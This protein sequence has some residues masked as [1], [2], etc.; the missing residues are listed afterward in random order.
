MDGGTEIRCWDDLLPDA[1]ELIF[2]KLSLQELLTVAPAVCKSWLRLVSGPHFWQEIDIEE[3]SRDN[4]SAPERVERLVRMLVSRSL[5]SFR[6][7]CVVGISNE[8]TFSFIADH[9]GSLQTLQVTRSNISDSVV[10]EIA[11]R[12]SNVTVLDISFCPKIGAVA[13]EAIGNN[14]KSL[15]ELRMLRDPM[16]DSGKMCQDDEAHAIAT[17]MPRLKRLDMCYCLL[18]NKGVVEIISNLKVLEFLD[19]VGCWDVEIDDKFLKETSTGLRVRGPHVNCQD[20]SFW[21][22]CSDYSGSS[23]YAAWEYGD[24]DFG[25]YDAD[26][27]DGAW[28]EDQGLDE[29][30]LRFYDGVNDVGFGLDWPPSP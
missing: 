26:S 19:I 6:K 7:L 29:L 30:E 5:G 15:V 25:D 20:Q 2:R 11:G 21:D 9:A 18:T 23:A 8:S 4:R 27:F 16:D 13:L 14:C 22:G 12:L 3:W 28:G 1:L 17:T 24:D 10:E